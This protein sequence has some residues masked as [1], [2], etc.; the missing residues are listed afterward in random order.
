MD[1]I[2]LLT[3]QGETM[4]ISLRVEPSDTLESIK[5]KV[6]SKA[7]IPSNQQ[8][9]VFA[10]VKIVDIEGSYL[11]DLVT[12]STLHFVIIHDE[13]NISGSIFSR[14]TRQFHWK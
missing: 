3:R 13:S 9:M 11:Y 5:A 2:V 8:M 10:G 6:Q 4:K 14:A 12:G 1:I 7:G